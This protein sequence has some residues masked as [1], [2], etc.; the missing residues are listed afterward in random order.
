[1]IRCRP[2]HG[3]VGAEQD[4]VLANTAAGI[5]HRKRWFLGVVVITFALHAKGPGFEPRRNLSSF[6]SFCSVIIGG[7]Y[8]PFLGFGGWLAEMPLAWE[9]TSNELYDFW[10]THRIF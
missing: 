10:S 2:E 4:R 1:M 7:N 6:F 5:A 9:M 8:I 3:V